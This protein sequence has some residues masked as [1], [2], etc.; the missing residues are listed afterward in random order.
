MCR[1]L[2]EYESY[3]KEIKT[4]SEK[5]AKMKA[6]KAEFHDVKQQ[7]CLRAFMRECVHSWFCRH[8]T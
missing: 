2:K 3:V 5:I 7:V 4:Q 8:L 1:T 6:E